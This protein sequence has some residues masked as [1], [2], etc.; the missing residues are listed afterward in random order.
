MTWLL[1]KL[2]IRLVIFLAVFFL[3]TK[4]NPAIVVKPTWALPVIAGFFA[5]VNTALYWILKPVLNLASFGAIWFLM[6][7]VLNLCFLIATVRVF[8]KTVMA[9]P[10]K[11]G[12]APPEKPKMLRRPTLEI[13]GIGATLYLAALLTVAHG[14]LWFGLDWCPAKFG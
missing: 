10:L 11:K 7:L 9:A 12:E 13:D 4:R 8:Q 1:I 5:L 2:G 14:V 6:P 3:A